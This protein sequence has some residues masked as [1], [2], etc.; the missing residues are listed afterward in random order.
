MTYRKW[1]YNFK[2][3]IHCEIEEKNHLV[4]SI[5]NEEPVVDTH[6]LALYF[7]HYRKNMHWYIFSNC[8][9]ILAKTYS[10][11]QPN[12][13]I[14]D[15]GVLSLILPPLPPKKRWTWEKRG[16]WNNRR[17]TAGS[18]ELVPMEGDLGF[19]PSAAITQKSS[20]PSWIHSMW[21]LPH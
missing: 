3:K 10:T 14:W 2:I 11:I 12:R 21:H 13:N 20:V 5:S 19:L 8:Q 15:H 18:R 7:F 6:T 4:G 17:G 9:C 16:F 1:S